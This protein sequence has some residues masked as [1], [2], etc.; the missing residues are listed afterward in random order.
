MVGD[1]YIAAGCADGQGY[2]FLAQVG[3]GFVVGELHTGE[4]IPV[5]LCRQRQRM[6]GDDILALD[7]AERNAC[8]EDF[9]TLAGGIVYRPPCFGYRC[10]GVALTDDIE[11]TA[12]AEPSGISREVG[13]CLLRS[14][15]LVFP[16]SVLD[17]ADGGAGIFSQYRHEEAFASGPARYEPVYGS[18]ETVGQ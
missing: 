14:V 3:D 17:V 12:V 6:G 18:R 9:Q 15:A 4:Y 1:E 5:Y 13:G 7:G 11:I 16:D 8:R 10:E 2:R